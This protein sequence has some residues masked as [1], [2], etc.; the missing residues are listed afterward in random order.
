MCDLLTL[1]HNTELRL[2]LESFSEEEKMYEF[3]HH[4]FRKEVDQII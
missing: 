1:Q 2:Y 3:E 4:K